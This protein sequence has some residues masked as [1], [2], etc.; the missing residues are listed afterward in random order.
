MRA[1]E[2]ISEV[3]QTEVRIAGF[4]VLLTDHIYDQGE[5]RGVS[6]SM[7]NTILKRL[8]RARKQILDIGTETSINIYDRVDNVHLVVTKPRE[9]SDRLQLVTTY[10]NPRYHGRNP[11]IVV[12]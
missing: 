10:I 3:R 2:F 11:V 1:H 4:D 6:R 7:I 9:D 5:D 12:R 8:G